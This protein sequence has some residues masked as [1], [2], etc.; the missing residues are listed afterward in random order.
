[1]RFQKLDLNLLIV[2]DALLRDRSVSLA[3]DRIGLSQSATSSALGRLRLY[4]D[5]ELLVMKGRQMVLTPR[6]EDLVV[7]VAE[8]LAQIRDT[9]AVAPPFDPTT[10][11]RR[12]TIIA[13]DYTIEVLLGPALKEI[14]LEAPYLQFELVPPGSNTPDLERGLVDLVLTTD[15]MVSTDHPSTSLFSDDYVVVAWVENE[16]VSDHISVELYSSIGHVVTKFGRERIP[17]FEDWVLRGQSIERRVEI[18][19]PDFTSVTPFI[20]G[21]NRIATMHQRLANRLALR[22]PLKI[23][24]VPF[25]I[26]QLTIAAQW[27]R[28]SASDHAILWLVERLKEVASRSEPKHF[29]DHSHRGTSRSPTGGVKYRRRAGA[30]EATDRGRPG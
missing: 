21:T 20:V 3:A 5:D 14:A 13:S 9:I 10:S 11:D 12:L 23:V 1:M 15:T 8:V 19:A 24:D 25:E 2:L 27:A 6:A 7:P 17:S 28:S 18:I 16:L 30:R 26:P 22:H 29:G 4:F